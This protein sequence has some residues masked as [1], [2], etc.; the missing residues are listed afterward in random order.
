MPP[1]QPQSK[2]RASLVSNTT[3][4]SFHDIEARPA[5][6]TATTTK[7]MYDTDNISITSEMHRQDSGYESI[8]PRDPQTTKGSRSSRR[9]REAASTTSSRPGSRARPSTRRSSKSG[10]V[11]RVPKTKLGS[12]PM[13]LTQSNP[14]SVRPS[15][16]YGYPDSA[17]T[18]PYNPHANAQSS[19]FH[20]PP[21][22]PHD[23]MLQDTHNS[24]NIH[25]IDPFDTSYNDTSGPLPSSP[26]SHTSPTSMYDTPPDRKSVV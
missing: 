24:H 11:T 21:P 8:S 20:F 10:P 15:S 19:Y 22:D 14:V 6:S 1:S 13:H 23:I 25:S 26:T 9:E 12:R 17:S 16:Y 2:S 5:T 7:R 3:Y 18:S 4:H